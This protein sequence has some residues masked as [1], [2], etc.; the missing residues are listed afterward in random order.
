MTDEY[1]YLWAQW[2]VLNYKQY[3]I[4]LKQFGDLETAWKKIDRQFLLRLGFGREKA[5]RLLS[6]RNGINFHQLIKRIENLNVRI[7]CVD[8]SDYPKCLRSIFSPPV[9]LFIRGQMPSLHKTLGVV[10]TRQITDY[11]KMTTEKFVSGLV[12][13]GF[14]IVSG[15]AFGVD[16]YAHQVTV[17]KDG[18]TVAVL[19]CGVD[20]IYPSANRYLAERIIKESGAV[21]SEYPLGT[22][23]MQHHFP[24]RNRIISGLSRGV[25]IVEGGVKSGA[26]ITARYAL[27]QGRE[28]FAIPNN[29]TKV[30]L[31][32]TNHLIRRGEA[33]L[34][35]NVDHILEEFQMQPVA[36]KQQISFS[37]IESEL[38]ERIMNGGKSID[39]LTVE[40][41]Y[42]VARLSE[43][44]INLQLKGVVREI[45]QKWVIV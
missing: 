36:S 41:P 3:Q 24:I 32:G 19:G 39:E 20:Q 37:A 6:I 34:V 13:N 5:E 12:E 11:G 22:P 25:L 1:V 28:V 27:E 45:G 21:I 10:G 9:F 42:N 23:A 43:V 15:L 16:A 33:K 18:L 30:G 17:K 4:V 38:L 14:V 8:D 44:F 35:E 29:I 7:L 31:S 2:G 26:L 40:T